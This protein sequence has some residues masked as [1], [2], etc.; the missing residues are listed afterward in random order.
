M[1]K[2]A[3]FAQVEDGVVRQVIVVNNADC[4]D[5][6]F[7]ESESVGQAF[8]NSI[9]LTGTWKQTSYNGNFRGQYAGA[10]HT[11][12]EELDEFVAPVGTPIVFPEP[13]P[14]PEPEPEPAP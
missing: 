2:I 11:Y 8:I 6:E 1:S 10:G 14:E 3:H 9:G 4:G 13:L 5:L 12:D 7:P